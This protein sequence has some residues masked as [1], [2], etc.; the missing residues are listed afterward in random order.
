MCFLI[1]TEVGTFGQP[2]E[3]VKFLE[4]V[5]IQHENPQEI[6]SELVHVLATFALPF[7]Q[8]SCR[9]VLPLACSTQIPH[10]NDPVSVNASAHSPAAFIMRE[11]QKLWRMSG[12]EVFW[13]SSLKTA[14]VQEWPHVEKDFHYV[15][16]SSFLVRSE[17]S[18]PQLNHSA[19]NDHLPS[20]LAA[21]TLAALSCDKPMTRTAH[22]AVVWQMSECTLWGW[23]LTAYSA[24]FAG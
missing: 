1:W 17:T 12:P 16:I 24:C 18:S 23:L 14:W 2:P 4:Y 20:E 22:S 3:I 7:P 8:Q 13:S 21:L 5:R 15:V 10:G 9:R 6:H 19:R 11:A